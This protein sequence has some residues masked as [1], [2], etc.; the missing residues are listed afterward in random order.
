MYSSFLPS[1]ETQVDASQDSGLSAPVTPPMTFFFFF[2]IA[3]NP[4]ATEVEAEEDHESKRAKM[5]FQ[6]KQRINQLREFHESMI[7]TV[8]VGTD[9]Y[10][11]MDS[12]EHE[13]NVDEDVHD[14]EFWSDEDQ[15]EFKGVARCVV[16]ESTVGQTTSST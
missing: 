13:A 10:A 11:T 4:M 9:E 3:T 1:M 14:V 12:Y 7:T 6:K 5:E 2:T 8:K 15:L 16:V